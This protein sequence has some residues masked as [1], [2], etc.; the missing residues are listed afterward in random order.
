[1][2]T[3]HRGRCKSVLRVTV[4]FASLAL[5]TACAG[6]SKVATGP[7]TDYYLSHAAGNYTPPGPP[8]DPWGPYIKIAAGRFDVPEQWVRQVMKVESGGHQYI[9][10]QLTVSSSGAMGL[11]QLEP[12]TY[13]EM[14]SRY[15]LGSDPF[16]PYDNIMA[17]TAYI[18]EMYSVY[19][20]PG[21]LAAYNAGPGRL[22]S[23]ENYH[24]P[25]PHETTN[26]VAM[27]AP[28]I[29]G[30][31]PQHRSE[32]DQL[33]LNTMPMSSGSGILPPG[34]APAPYPTPDTPSTPLAP[35]E[36]ADLAPPPSNQSAMYTPGPAPSAP[37]PQPP[38]H[39][40]GFSFIPS[41][42]ADTPPPHMQL[43]PPAPPPVRQAVYAPPPVHEMA[44][45]GAGGG[46]G[47]WAVQVGAYNTVDKAKAALGIAELSAVQMLL[48]GKPVVASVNNGLGTIYRARFV[49]LP[50]DQAVDACQRLSGGPTGCVILSP[51]AQS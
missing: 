1:M 9:G 30:Y 10:G 42:M 35:V 45:S 36:V 7:S 46:T 20:S 12:E 47:G 40:S 8:D 38:P 25:L 17:G 31:Y 2:P 18:H 51:D 22:D 4:S 26:Y 41:A 19:G 39:G 33:A 37:A 27:I 21:F 50:H 24:Q 23:F 32:A 29:Q 16:N 11:M 15:G 6:G 13:Q 28:R 43:P 44:S 14:A 48:H 34:V 3:D 49:G 5:L